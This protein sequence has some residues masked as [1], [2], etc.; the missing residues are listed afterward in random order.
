MHSHLFDETVDWSEPQREPWSYCSTRLFSN[1]Q[2]FAA[3][4]FPPELELTERGSNSQ[5]KEQQA[6]REEAELSA[7]Y[8]SPEQIPPTP[9]E[10]VVVL[11][12]DQLDA[13]VKSMVVGEKVDG[14]F[15]SGAPPTGP[16]SVAD[17]VGQLTAGGGDVPM[18]D[19]TGHAWGGFD[20]GAMSS[21]Q[22]QMLVQQARTIFSQQQQQQPQGLAPV[23]PGSGA[24]PFDGGADH[25]WNSQYQDF[26]REHRD[27]D[28]GHGRWD[29]EGGGHG[30]GRGRG[31]GRGRGGGGSSGNGGGGFRHNKR[32]PCSFYMQGRRASKSKCCVTR[33][34]TDGPML[35][36]QIRRPMRFQ[37]RPCLLTAVGSVVFTYRLL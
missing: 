6:R 8:T 20:V 29:G 32:T 3:V 9:G 30:G 12:D 18:G 28:A 34:L 26:G 4:E 31:R 15:W 17:L 14:I 27:E 23:G 11:P 37:P 1:T 19:A 24:P 16:A 36:V 21:E 22:L 35:Q 7:I 13:E 10:P 25:N 2:A 5:E 33:I